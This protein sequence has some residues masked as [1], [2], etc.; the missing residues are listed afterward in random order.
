MVMF[1]ESNQEIEYSCGPVRQDRHNTTG[2]GEKVA[3]YWEKLSRLWL[4][5]SMRKDRVNERTVN[6]DS[7]PERSWTIDH[8]LG[9]NFLY[10][11]GNEESAEIHKVGSNMISLV[12]HKPHN[13][14]A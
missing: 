10:C 4:S 5:F 2:K 14:L 3:V 9:F 1:G 6:S 8:F 11:M 12:F 7:Y 13:V